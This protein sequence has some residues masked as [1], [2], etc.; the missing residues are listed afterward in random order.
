MISKSRGF[1]QDCFIPSMW[2]V[3]SVSNIQLFCLAPSSM[4]QMLSSLRPVERN[5]R[6]LTTKKG[7]FDWQ[8]NPPFNYFSQPLLIS[9]SS[10]WT[11]L[12]EMALPLQRCTISLG[13]HFSKIS[14]MCDKFFG[15]WVHTS[16]HC[17]M[18]S[19]V[20]WYR[21]CWACIRASWTHEVAQWLHPLSR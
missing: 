6:N 2:K 13:G 1:G 4:K 7:P 3:R 14:A 17:G 15:G 20:L 8:Q 10:K 16:T 5:I 12:I 21:Q 11:C 9:Q 19:V 18:V